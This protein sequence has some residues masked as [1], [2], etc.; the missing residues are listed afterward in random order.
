MKQWSKV[1]A[2]SC[3]LLVA[4]ANAQDPSEGPSLRLSGFGT[5]SLTRAD[6]PTGWGF[7]REF[8]QPANDGGLRADVDTRLGLQ[9]NLALGERVQAVAQ[10][11]VKDRV[12]GAQATDSIE[13]AF[14]SWRPDARTTLRV[15]RISP[16]LYF[17]ADVRNVGFAYGSVRP[18]VEFYGALPLH[19]ID[20]GDVQRVWTSGETHW[21]ARLTGGFNSKIAVDRASDGG[22]AA[23]YAFDSLAA[24]SLTRSQGGLALKGMLARTV[25]KPRLSEASEHLAQELRGVAALP[26]S[27]VAAEAAA[28]AGDLS[29]RRGTITFASLGVDYSAGPWRLVAEGG[30]LGGDFAFMNGSY[31]YALASRQFGALTPYALVG[32]AR[33]RGQP[34]SLP[35]WEAALSP[36]I[37]PAAAAQAQALGTAV[38]E[39]FVN[40]PR[41]DQSSWALGLRWDLHPQAALKLQWERVRVHPNGSGLWANATAQGAVNHVSSVS[42]DF[43]F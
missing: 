22:S 18:P 28:L 13:W 26:V 33:T 36:A 2:R 4:S 12:R 42:L 38:V 16:N 29:L 25:I 39:G 6:A 40:G 35:Q 41:F 21:Q 15:G 31:G 7:L 23:A 3:L 10:V 27:A 19:W 1:V 9:A 34:G 43:V 20:G 5:L 24:A 30:R 32:R 11:I 37:G 17:G 14:V 8:T